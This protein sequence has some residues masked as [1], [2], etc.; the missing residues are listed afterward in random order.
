MSIFAH[1]LNKVFMATIFMPTKN[2]RYSERIEDVCPVIVTLTTNDG[3]RFKVKAKTKNISAGGLYMYVPYLLIHCD[4]LFVFIQLSYG[5]RL[6]AISRVLRTEN[7][8]DE[9][10]GVALCFERTRLFPV[11]YS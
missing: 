1:S 4:I 7:K 11:I 9:L 8:G 10:L 2:N 6:A 3:N 5:A